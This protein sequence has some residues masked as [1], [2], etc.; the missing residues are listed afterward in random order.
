MMDPDGPDAVCAALLCADGM[1]AMDKVSTPALAV[2]GEVGMGCGG[3][4]TVSN[5]EKSSRNVAMADDDIESDKEN[6]PISA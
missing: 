6:A 3:D 4:A 2:E 1:M 5:A